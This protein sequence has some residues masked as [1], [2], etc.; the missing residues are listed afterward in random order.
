MMEGDLCQISQVVLDRRCN[1]TIVAPPNY[2]DLLILYKA[3]GWYGPVLDYD[4]GI[5]WDI[6]RK[7]IWI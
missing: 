1:I 7:S 4:V 5:W 3:I 6:E 2:H